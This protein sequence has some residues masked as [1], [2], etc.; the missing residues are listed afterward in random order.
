MVTG[1]RQG[2]LLALLVAELRALIDRLRRTAMTILTDQNGQPWTESG[3]RTMFDRAKRKAGIAGKTFH[4]ARG[5]FVTRTVVHGLTPQEV[6]TITGH[7]IK[8]VECILDTY[9]AR[10]P[11]LT[12]SAMQ[13]YESGTKS[14]KRTG[15]YVRLFRPQSR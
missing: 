13:K 12:R 15:K 7:S 2:D 10:S 11:E 9:T 14:G 3:Y 8:D 1:Q 5:T 6:A 4:D